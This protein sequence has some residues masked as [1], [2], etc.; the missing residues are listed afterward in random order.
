MPRV[1]GVALT[2]AGTVVCEP[3]LRVCIETPTPVVG[4][5]LAAAARLGGAVEPT[6]TGD[7]LSVITATMATATR[8]GAPSPHRRPHRRRRRD[9]DRVRG[10]PTGD[11]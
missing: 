6:A 11:G 7:E 3:M 1:L 10:L 8:A 4:T 2:R 9:R 5:V